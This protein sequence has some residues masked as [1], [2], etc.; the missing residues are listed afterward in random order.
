MKLLRA[1]FTTNSSNFKK[2][3]NKNK[4]AINKILINN[5]KNTYLN[6]ASRT[7]YFF[8]INCSLIKYY[9][10]PNT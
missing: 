7:L 6:M 5:Y 9:T 3:E 2:L 1:T 10:F 4:H 8:S